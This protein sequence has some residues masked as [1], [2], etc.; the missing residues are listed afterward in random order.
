[1]REVG[2][3][4]TQRAQSW[5]QPCCQRTSSCHNKGKAQIATPPIQANLQAAC[6]ARVRL[7]SKHNEKNRKLCTA[8][9]CVRTPVAA[10]TIFIFPLR[11]P[12]NALYNKRWEKRL[13]CLF[14]APMTHQALWLHNPMPSSHGVRR[15]K[16]PNAQ[17]AT[18]TQLT[19]CL[20]TQTV[21]V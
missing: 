17:A 19:H 5:Q 2:R 12:T 1:M 9:I 21:V 18:H 16:Q 3:A 10:T 8:T 7:H 15:N 4:N 6:C 20:A 13:V 14:L 11:K